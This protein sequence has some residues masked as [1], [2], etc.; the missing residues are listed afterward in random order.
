LKAAVSEMLKRNKSGMVFVEAAMILPLIIL[1]I[2]VIIGY[3]ANSCQEVTKRINGHIEL[4]EKQ[5][6]ECVNDNRECR[7]VRNIDFIMEEINGDLRRE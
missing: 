3:A 5:A 2:M 6:D 1:T 4:R 7:F